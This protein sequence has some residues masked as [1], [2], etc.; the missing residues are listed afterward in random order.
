MA[1]TIIAAVR[2][3]AEYEKALHTDVETIFFLSPSILNLENIVRLAKENHKQLYIHLDLTAGLGKDKAALEFVSALGIDGIIST[4][5]NLIKAAR[6]CGLKT[7]QRFFVVDSQ[8]LETTVETLKN[9]KAD[10][11]E[12]MPGIMPKIMEKLKERVETPL[13]AGGLIES[14]EDVQSVLQSGAVAISTGSRILWNL[15]G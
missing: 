1:H 6:E 11:A 4:R 12:I 10:M 15:P 8:S 5:S 7:V 14:S 3:E 13:I 9:S 2:S